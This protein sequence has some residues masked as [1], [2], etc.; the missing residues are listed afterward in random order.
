MEKFYKPILEYA[1]EKKIPILDI[2]NTFNPYH[3]KS[4]SDRENQLYVCSIEP[5]PIGGELI[6]EGIDHI[7]KNHDFKRS[8]RIYS[9]KADGGEYSSIDNKPDEWRVGYVSSES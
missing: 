5:G 1:E 4:L 8:S 2:T 7:V 6:A 3:D 9:K